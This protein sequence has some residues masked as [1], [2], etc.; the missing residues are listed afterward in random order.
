[1]GGAPTRAEP[2]RVAVLGFDE[3]TVSHAAL[4]Q[5]IFRILNNFLRFCGGRLNVFPNTAIPPKKKNVI[6]FYRGLGRFK[7]S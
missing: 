6:C 3:I 7:R 1:M 2:F 4:S 5:T